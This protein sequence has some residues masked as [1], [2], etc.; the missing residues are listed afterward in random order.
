M[1]KVRDLNTCCANPWLQPWAP[2]A[3]RRQVDQERMQGV[4]ASQVRSPAQ[5]LSLLDVWVQLEAYDRLC[6]QF[7]P[8][9]RRALGRVSIAW[10]TKRA[11]QASTA[12]ERELSAFMAVAPLLR[13]SAPALISAIASS[14]AGSVVIS[15]WGTSKPCSHY[16]TL[17]G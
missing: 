10:R 17:W 3:A 13:C 1:L 2:W 12:C 11:W 15:V 7:E 4:H 6:Q 9:P 8:R 14:A 16:T 5:M